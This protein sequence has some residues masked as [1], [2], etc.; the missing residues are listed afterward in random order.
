MI[1]IAHGAMTAAV[2]T[3][4]MA[5]SYSTRRVVDMNLYITMCGGAPAATVASG[6]SRPCYRG[7]LKM[8]Q[9]NRQ[10]RS[11]PREQARMDLHGAG[12]E[13]PPTSVEACPDACP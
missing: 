5:G 10:L 11:R 4:E 3:P 8:A 6:S 12:E 13:T 1:S 9:Q 7:P 2:E